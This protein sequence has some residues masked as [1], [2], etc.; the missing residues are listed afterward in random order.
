MK[1]IL[2]LIG[3]VLL[4]FLGN[5]GIRLFNKFR[6]AKRL[7]FDVQSFSFPDGLKLS[8]IVKDVDVLINQA[9][10]NFSKTPF[11]IE[12]LNIEVFSPSGKLIAEQKAPLEQPIQIKPNQTT[13]FPIRFTIS[14]QNMLRL[15][16][17]AGGVLTVGANFLSTGEYGIPLRMKGFVDADGITVDIDQNITV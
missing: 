11:Q 4:L 7:K 17:E 14:P 12:Q 15:I 10:A 6:H 2:A 13:V 3:I 1:R 5:K 16:K 9:V 8:N